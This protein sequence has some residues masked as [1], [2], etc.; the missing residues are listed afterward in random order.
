[1]LYPSTMPP[2]SPP[3]RRAAVPLLVV[4]AVAAL[5]AA[6]VPLFRRLDAYVTEREWGEI[7][8]AYNI[9][10]DTGNR[11][12]VAWDR[13]A[14]PHGLFPAADAQHGWAHQR[15]AGSQRADDDGLL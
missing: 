13:T 12:A 14:N 8:E 15:H 9:N 11:E 4:A 2:T 5:A 10:W 1:M 6:A 7:A 3:M